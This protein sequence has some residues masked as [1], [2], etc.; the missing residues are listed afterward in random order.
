M[1]YDSSSISE[2]QKQLGYVIGVIF[3]VGLSFVL[4]TSFTAAFISTSPF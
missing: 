1:F 3:H 4:V 2:E